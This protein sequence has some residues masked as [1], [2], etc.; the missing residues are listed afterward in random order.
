M[1][2]FHTE[3]SASTI[4]QELTVGIKSKRVNIKSVYV[5]FFLLTKWNK[6]VFRTQSGTVI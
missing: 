4:Y 2:E 3:I 5:C 1:E 6:F